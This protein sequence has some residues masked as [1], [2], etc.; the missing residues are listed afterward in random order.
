MSRQGAAIARLVS[1]D[2]R[3]VVRL[4]SVK[5]GRT[6]GPEVELLDHPIRSGERL[7]VNPPDDLR[8]GMIVNAQPIEQAMLPLMRPPHPSEPRA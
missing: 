4:T 3:Q 2:G 6:F 7:V 5:I 1:S 8:D